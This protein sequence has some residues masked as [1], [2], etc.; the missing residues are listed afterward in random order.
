[1]PEVAEVA[2]VPEVVLVRPAAVV[3]VSVMGAPMSGAVIPPAVPAPIVGERLT[4]QERDQGQQRDR[5]PLKHTSHA[6][7]SFH[8]C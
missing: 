4:G 1:M 3:S 7:T 5:E 2:V 6:P 8:P